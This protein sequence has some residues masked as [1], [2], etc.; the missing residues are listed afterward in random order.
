MHTQALDRR[1]GNLL[2]TWIYLP[3]RPEVNALFKIPR[4]E[5]FHVTLCEQTRFNVSFRTASPDGSKSL[6]GAHFADSI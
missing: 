3:Y 6:A 4:R 1:I 5:I 2:I